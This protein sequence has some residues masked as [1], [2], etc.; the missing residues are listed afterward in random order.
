MKEYDGRYKPKRQNKDYTVREID[1]KADAYETQGYTD[2][3]QYIQDGY[4]IDEME[5]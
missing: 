4:Y 5:N 2:D 1:E 3:Q